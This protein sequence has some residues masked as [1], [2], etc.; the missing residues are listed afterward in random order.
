MFRYEAHRASRM[1]R[2]HQPHLTS[3][4]RPHYG[5]S[6]GWWDGNTLVIETINLPERLA[7]RGYSAKNMRLIERFTR[8]APNK[9]EWSATIDAPTIWTRPWTYSYPMTEDNG[10]PIFEYAC[11]EGNFGLANILTAGR[12]EDRKAAG[13]S[14]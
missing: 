12:A 4:I 6:I 14:R 9:V 5:D 11:H 10:Q 8:I 2:L 7:Y 13:N 1:I 3:A